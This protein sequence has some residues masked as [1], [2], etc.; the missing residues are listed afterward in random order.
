MNAT[1][2][3]LKNQMSIIG[4]DYLIQKDFRLSLEGYYKRYSD[5]PTGTIPGVTD[6]IV[7]TNTGTGFGGSQDDFQSFGYYDLRSSAKGQSFGLDVLFQKKFSEIPCYGQ[8]SFTLGESKFIAGNGQ[9]YPGQFDQHY[10]FNLSGGYIFNKNWEFSSKFRL[11]SGIPYTPVYRPSENPV[12]P[13]N[14]ENLPEEYLS[15]RLKT[16]HHLDIRVDR[17][18]FRNNLTLIIFVDIQNI[19]NFKIPQRPRYD[20]WTDEVITSSDI[21]ILPSI[22][23]SAEL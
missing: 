2:K 16:A 10:I 18:F 7:I 8:V 6:Y 1:L 19:Y 21:G 17:Y 23:I 11:F 15:S 4:L 12:K 20:F 22:G 5:L 13:G 14:I 3:A 9:Q